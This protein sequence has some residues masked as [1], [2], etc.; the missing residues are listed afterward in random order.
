MFTNVS[1]MKNNSQHKNY[2]CPLL[3]TDLKGT[4]TTTVQ[5]PASYSMDEFE[6]ASHQLQMDAANS[7]LVLGADVLA[8]SINYIFKTRAPEHIGDPLNDRA[9]VHDH[10]LSGLFYG[11]LEHGEG[12][13]MSDAI[14]A[15]P[16][17]GGATA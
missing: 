17:K 4:I 5:I 12:V 13:W 15:Y 1:S 6:D 14:Y 11:F 2:W 10:A 16:E 8:N 3:T 9:A 7:P